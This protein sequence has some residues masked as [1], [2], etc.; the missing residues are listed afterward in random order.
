MSVESHSDRNE[1]GKKNDGDT[2]EQAKQGERA[3]TVDV[4]PV[5]HFESAQFTSRLAN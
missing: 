1:C 4:L 3:S 2:R 5:L